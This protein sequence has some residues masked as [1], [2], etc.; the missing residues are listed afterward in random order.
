MINWNSIIENLSD[1]NVVSVDPEEK[2]KDSSK[3]V[4]GIFDP[5]DNNFNLDMD[6]M[7]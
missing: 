6:K 1:G 7:D 4:I 2:I 3:S 5:E